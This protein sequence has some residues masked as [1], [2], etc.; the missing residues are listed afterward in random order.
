MAL[1]PERWRRIEDVVNAALERPF[2]AIACARLQTITAF[3]LPPYSGVRSPTR[4]A[5]SYSL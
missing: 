5:T 2:H 3:S 1:T 4:S